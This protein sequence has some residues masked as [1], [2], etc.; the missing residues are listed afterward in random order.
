MP[1]DDNDVQHLRTRVHLDRTTS[2]LPGES[3]IGTQQQL[4]P[5]LAA[6]IERARNLRATKRTGGKQAAVFARERNPLCNALVDDI[7]AHLCEPVYIGFAG[8]KIAALD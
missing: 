4:L 6:R 5:G 8:P 2:N 7:Y 1:I 3:L